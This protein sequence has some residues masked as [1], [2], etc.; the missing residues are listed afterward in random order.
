MAIRFKGGL[1]ALVALVAIS[2]TAQVFQVQGGVSTLLNAQGGSVQIK[3]PNYDSNLGVGFFNGHFELG[4]ETRYLSHGYTVI[5]GDDATPFTLPTDILDSS[6]YFSTRGAGVARKDGDQNIYVFAGTTSTWLGTGFF[7]AAKS[8]NPV[9]LFF[10]ERKLNSQLKLVSRNIASNRQTFL[11][12]VEWRPE[13]WMTAALTGGVGSNQKY[14]ASSIDLETQ[15]LALKSAYFLT[16]TM[17][18]RITV[19]S[20]MSSEEN[21]GNVEMLYKPEEH[22]SIT[23]GHQNILEPLTLAAPMQQASVNQL[24]TDF[25]VAKFY[26]GSGLFSS[27]AEGRSSQG[28]NFYLGRRIGQRLEANANYFE[29]KSHGGYNSNILSGTI[30]ENFSSRFS[31]LQLVSR[32]A[33]QTTVAFGGDFTSN[34]LLLRADY[35]NVYLPFR[36]QNP[37]EQALALN[38]NF[39][40]KGPL[41]LTMASNVAPD[42]HL[43]Y[44]FGASTYLYRVSGMM[45]NANSESFSI[46][47]Y[48]VQGLVTD[49]QQAPIEGV[50]LHIA[51]QVAYTDSTG[52]FMVRFSKHGPFPV[53]VALDEFITTGTY[54]VVS[55]PSPVRAEAEDAGRSVNVVLRRVASRPESVRNGVK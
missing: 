54:T 5:A 12:G 25:H 41:Q 42:G 8:D 28:T 1:C 24:S 15:T 22:V 47:K 51:N 26:F 16:G 53:S 40:V 46:G 55:V 29:S 38:V 19:A 18:Q 43:R 34:R 11:Q 33:G 6:H 23:A 37:F 45:V 20:P 44:S 10:Y 50:A 9:A 31:F 36:P 4:A 49:E 17:F 52:H 48:V 3:A 35:Q 7:N 39:R 32:T 30:R 27:T 2:S 13:K 21:K 14:F